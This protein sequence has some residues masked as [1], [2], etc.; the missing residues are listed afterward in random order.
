MVSDADILDAY[1]LMARREGIFCEPAS[2]AGVAGLIKHARAGLE[3]EGRRVVCIVTGTGLKD[4]DLANEMEPE[5]MEEYP[6]DVTA[7]EQ[8][9][10]EGL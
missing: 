10:A 5:W 4:P 3:L 6:P 7:V 1:K 9:L 2:A 8:A